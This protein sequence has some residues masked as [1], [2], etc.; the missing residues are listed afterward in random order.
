MRA[1]APAPAPSRRAVAPD[2]RAR[3]LSAVRAQM[4][5]RVDELERRYNSAHAL[6]QAA[7]AQAT[8]AEAALE[9]ARAAAELCKLQPGPPKTNYEAGVREGIA[10]VCS[11]IQAA[12]MNASAAL[13]PPTC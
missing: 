9:R 3:A 8:A 10:I 13:D 6:H 5:K 4:Q 12:E 2:W 7:A 1:R 11:A